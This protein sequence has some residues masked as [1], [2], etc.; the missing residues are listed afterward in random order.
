MPF[1]PELKCGLPHY[2]GILFR[3]CLAGSSWFSALASAF[4]FCQ[5]SAAQC[6]T[7]SLLATAFFANSVMSLAAR[8]RNSGG[9]TASA[10]VYPQSRANNRPT[11]R[12]RTPRPPDVERRNMPVTDALFLPRVGR[13][14]F[15]G[16][17]NFDKP[18]GI[19][20]QYYSAWR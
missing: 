2:A 16:Q 14:A 8:S 19:V 4:H 12:Q 1:A 17:V 7:K 3:T 15:D 18:F 20:H 11:R 6:F 13:N 9:H 5:V 10:G